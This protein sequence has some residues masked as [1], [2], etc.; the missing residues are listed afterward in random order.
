MAMAVES[1][2]EDKMRTFDVRDA[3]L[4]IGLAAVAG[5]FWFVW[6]PLAGIVPGLILTAVAVFGVR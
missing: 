1:A 6:P 2:A 3:I 4:V 5:G